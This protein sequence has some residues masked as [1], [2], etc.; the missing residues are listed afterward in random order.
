MECLTASRSN[1]G[2]FGGLGPNGQFGRPCF[3]GQM[4]ET[5]GKIPLNKVENRNAKPKDKPYKMGDAAGLFLLF[6]PTGGKLWRFKYRIDGKEKICPLVAIQMSRLRRRGKYET[7]RG[8]YWRRAMTLHAK[9]QRRNCA[10]PPIPITPMPRLPM[11]IA[12]SP[13]HMAKNF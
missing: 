7:Q 6:Q 9:R 10:L 11:N 3:G 8:C 5:A 13:P 12:K 4:L 1:S 2:P